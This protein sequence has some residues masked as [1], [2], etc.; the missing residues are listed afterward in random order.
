AATGDLRVQQTKT[1][2]DTLSQSLQ[3]MLATVIGSSHS[4]VRVTADLD[5]D[6]RQTK[7]ESFANDK[8]APAVSES[9]T[10]EKLAGTGAAASQGTLGPTGGATTG[11]GSGTGDYAKDTAERTYAVGKVTEEIKQAPGT[12]K[13]L[14]VA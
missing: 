10:S 12:V 1:Y 3:D 4:V 2:E 13:R 14:S 7:T 5:F 6:Q 11:T 9:V 8:Q